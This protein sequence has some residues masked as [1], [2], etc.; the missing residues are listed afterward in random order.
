[1]SVPINILP[2]YT[3]IYGTKSIQDITIQNQEVFFTFGTVTQTGGSPANYN[4]G[5]S[6]L[7]PYKESVNLIYGGNS[8][9]YVW[10][11][12]IVLTETPLDIT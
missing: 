4:I 2:G 6:C 5:T 8:Y 11:D 12:S 9:F 1:M 10:E 7:F 3:L